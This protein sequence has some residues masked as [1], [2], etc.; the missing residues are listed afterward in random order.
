MGPERDFYEEGQRTKQTEFQPGIFVDL[1]K[2]SKKAAF[3]KMLT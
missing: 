3:K 2:L 1:I